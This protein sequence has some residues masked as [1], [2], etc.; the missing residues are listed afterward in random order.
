MLWKT[1]PHSVQGVGLGKCL[2]SM[3]QESLANTLLQ[4]GHVPGAFLNSP[5]KRRNSASA[6]INEQ[7]NWSTFC[8]NICGFSAYFGKRT[9]FHR[10]HKEGFSIPNECLQCGASNYSFE[11][12]CSNKDIQPSQLLLPC[13]LRKVWSFKS[14][15]SVKIDHRFNH[16]RKA[17]R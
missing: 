15:I 17:S 8:G 3:W 14:F 6:A 13:I 16:W 5:V 4:Q 11:Y 9:L 1:L 12:F 10:G 2:S 7:E